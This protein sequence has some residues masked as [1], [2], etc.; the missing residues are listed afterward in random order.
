[1]SIILLKELSCIILFL[2]K[3]YNTSIISEKYIVTSLMLI[4]FFQYKNN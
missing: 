3:W 2:M 1:M 4:C